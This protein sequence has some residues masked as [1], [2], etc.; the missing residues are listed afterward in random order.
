MSRVRA[1]PRSK[2]RPTHTSYPHELGRPRSGTSALPD[3]CH[4]C[5]CVFPWSS[6]LYER[7][8][9]RHCCLGEAGSHGPARI[10]MEPPQSARDHES[11]LPASNS[12]GD[13]LWSCELHGPDSGRDSERSPL[14]TCGLSRVS[15]RLLQCASQLPQTSCTMPGS[16][17]AGLAPWERPEGSERGGAWKAFD[18]C[19]LRVRARTQESRRGS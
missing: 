18:K 10:G 5:V 1:S 15:E 2:R 14:R 7:M 13:P 6:D 16:S 3:F 11:R 12:A 8:R 17:L 4:V 19:A 9:F